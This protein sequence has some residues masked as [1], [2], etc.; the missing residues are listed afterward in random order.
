MV[1]LDEVKAHIKVENYN[2]DALIRTYM[3]AAEDVIAG[4]AG[5]TLKNICRRW[6]RWL[7]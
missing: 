5:R 6:S 3:A 7:A 2:E 4:T 1:T